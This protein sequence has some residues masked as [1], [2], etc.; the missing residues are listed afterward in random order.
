[1]L[2]VV[3]MMLLPREVGHG[4]YRRDA[5]VASVEDALAHR[6]VDIIVLAQSRVLGRVARVSEVFHGVGHALYHFPNFLAQRRLH[7]VISSAASV[8]AVSAGEIRKG[9]FLLL[10]SQPLVEFV[11]LHFLDRVQTIDVGFLIG[12]FPPPPLGPILL[13]PEDGIRLGEFGPNVE[14]G[15]FPFGRSHFRLV[16]GGAE[17]RKQSPDDAFSFDVALLQS[18]LLLL[19]LFSSGDYFAIGKLP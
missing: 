6:I 19:V 4:T 16:G 17:L 1:M 14:E 5:A 3:V 13:F 15:A 10:A 12:D 9:P 11:L 2:L 18:Q 7:R 8:G